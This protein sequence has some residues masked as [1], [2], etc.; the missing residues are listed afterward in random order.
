MSG[1]HT[2]TPWRVDSKYRADIIGADGRDVAETAL[3]ASYRRP[4]EDQYANAAFIVRACNAHEA[5]RE[6]L[7]HAFDALHAHGG[8]AYEENGKTAGVRIRAAL[9]LAEES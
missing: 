3:S 2:P 5:M 4:L 9:K 8:L 7:K 1:K 6:A